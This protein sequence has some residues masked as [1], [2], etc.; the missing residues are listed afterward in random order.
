MS[1]EEEIFD[2]W[3]GGGG[4]LLTGQNLDPLCIK[5]ISLYVVVHQLIVRDYWNLLA[6]S[7]KL[8][9]PLL[10]KLKIV[11]NFAKKE[12]TRENFKLT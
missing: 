8:G 1:L 6:N 10:Q 11:T 2:F 3:R 12:S 7:F 9:L 5:K 4:M